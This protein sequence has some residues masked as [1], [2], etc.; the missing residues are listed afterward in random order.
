[1]PIEIALSLFFDPVGY[2]GD[3]AWPLIP[4][5]YILVG[6]CMM[7]YGVIWQPGASLAALATVGV[8]ALVYRFGV[9]N[10]RG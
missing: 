9:G 8:G 3:I 2:L 7:I 4:A 6:T 10:R 5:S 1:M